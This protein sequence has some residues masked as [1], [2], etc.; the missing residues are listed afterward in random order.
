M[1]KTITNFIDRHFKYYNVVSL[2]D[3]SISYKNHIEDWG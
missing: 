3:T 2:R 1:K